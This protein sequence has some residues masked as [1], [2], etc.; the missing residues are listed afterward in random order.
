MGCLFLMEQPLF[1]IMKIRIQ[2]ALGGAVND[3][4]G[5]S[6][7]IFEGTV[8]IGAGKNDHSYASPGAIY[9]FA[10]NQDGAN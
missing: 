10:L 1:I 4:F 6:I 3:A 2:T 8:V 5:Y 7:S 9:I